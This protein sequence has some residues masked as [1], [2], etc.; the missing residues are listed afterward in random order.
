[1]K[2]VLAA[3]AVAGFALASPAVAQLRTMQMDLNG[4]GFQAYS[5]ANGT[6]SPV[7]FGG[8][9]HS[10][11]LVFN[12][13]A[14][15]VL[16]DIAM[17]TNGV[18]PF[19]P[20]PFTGSLGASSVII[21]LSAGAVTGGSMM[22]HVGADMYST[23]IG[24]A[25]SVTTFVGGGY[26]VDGLTANGSF[27]GA[28]FATVPIADF[29]ANNGSLPGHFLSFA[30]VPDPQGSGSADID[31]FVLNIPA[32]GSAALLGLGGVLAFRRRR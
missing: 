5:G 10:G 17:Q 14:G 31:L 4:L 27:S 26:K 3:I 23:T 8:T 18:G 15:S 24:S 21:N 7:A 6:G 25:G 29:F 28:T 20:Q 30:I 22:I 9:S 32:P 1:M 19:L 16:N 11:S 12:T 13:I 2:S